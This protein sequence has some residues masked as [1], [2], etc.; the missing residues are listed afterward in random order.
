M[1]TNITVLIEQNSFKKERCIVLIVISS[2]TIKGIKILVSDSF[3]NPFYDI[4][5]CSLERRATL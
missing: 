1:V 4:V 5:V 3:Q 2:F